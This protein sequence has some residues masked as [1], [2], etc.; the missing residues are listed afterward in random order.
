GLSKDEVDVNATWK[1][2]EDA[3]GDI[4]ANNAC[5]LSYET[6]FGN[7]YK[8]VLKKKQDVLYDREG[9][10]LVAEADASTFC[11]HTRRRMREEDERLERELITIHIK[12]VINI[13]GTGVKS[14][15]NNN[16]LDDLANIYELVSR[17]DRRK[18]HLKIALHNVPEKK[19][20]PK[21]AEPKDT[22]DG[23][24]PA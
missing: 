4:H 18:T 6:L 7:A 20:L 11:S 2:L 24:S 3:F 8:L 9:L 19:A 15:L 10:D 17:T 14:M 5:S 12:D 22:K 23:K 16:H 21:P 13:E 1:I